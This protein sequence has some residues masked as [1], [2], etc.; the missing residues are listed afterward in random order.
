LLNL[1]AKR[2]QYS[3]PSGVLENIRLKPDSEESWP[4]TV[5]RRWASLDWGDGLG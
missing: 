1:D 3:D 5:Q 4:E 2:H